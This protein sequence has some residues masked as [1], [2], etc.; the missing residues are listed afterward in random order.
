MLAQAVKRLRDQRQGGISAIIAQEKPQ[1]ARRETVAIDLPMPTYIPTD[2]VPDLALRI[3]LYRRMAELHNEAAIAD[4]RAELE[5]RFGPL[6]PPAENLLFQLRVKQLALRAG[7]DSITAEGT[8]ISIRME[9]LEHADRPMLQRQL[10]HG[11]R[12][13]RTAIWFPRET[14]NWPSALISVLERLTADHSAV[15]VP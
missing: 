1:P 7:V 8:Q 14:D 6:L 3:Q 4:L 10:G 15:S 2:Y 5:D 11:V 12:V 13:S 9:A